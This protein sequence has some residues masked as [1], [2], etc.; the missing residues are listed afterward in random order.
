MKLKAAS[1]GQDFLMF[2]CELFKFL[3]QAK[4][5]TVFLMMT[6]PYAFHPRTF[7]DNGPLLPTDPNDR[8][9]IRLLIH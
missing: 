3:D 6:T 1:S 5:I 8:R 2:W 7:L 9:I 4:H